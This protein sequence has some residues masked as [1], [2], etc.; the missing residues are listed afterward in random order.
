MYVTPKEALAELV[1]LNCRGI[2]SFII[3]LCARLKYMFSIKT[4][5]LFLSRRLQSCFPF[6]IQ[7][8]WLNKFSTLLGKKVVMLTGE[9]ATDLK[10]LSK[11]KK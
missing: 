7:A 3:Y 2:Q 10:L 9:T 8:D 1:G 6:Q 5:A 4:S 11:V